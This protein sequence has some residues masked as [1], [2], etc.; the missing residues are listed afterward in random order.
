MIVSLL[1]IPDLTVCDK[2]ATMLKDTAVVLC[3]MCTIERKLH[4]TFF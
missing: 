1:A 3:A 4:I 2:R